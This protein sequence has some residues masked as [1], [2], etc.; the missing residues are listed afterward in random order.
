VAHSNL[1]KKLLPPLVKILAVFITVF[2]IIG[3]VLAPIMENVTDIW[4]GFG[5]ILNGLI[6]GDMT[7]AVEGLKQL[8]SC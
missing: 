3:I 5:N 6:N 4:K 8:G 1:I 2:D 7:M